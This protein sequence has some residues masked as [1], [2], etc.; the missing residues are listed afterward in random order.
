[1]SAKVELILTSLISIFFIIIG[2]TLIGGITGWIVGI[3]FGNQILHVFR[4]VGIDNITMWQL[5]LAL[6][7]ISG[8]YISHSNRNTHD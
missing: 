2:N 7:F 8:F 3:I 4:Q 6:G 1:M 5:G